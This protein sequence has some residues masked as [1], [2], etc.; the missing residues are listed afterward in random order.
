MEF[1]KDT[2]KQ[3]MFNT[4]SFNLTRYEYIAENESLAMEALGV[5][6]P[7]WLTDAAIQNQGPT[8]LIDFLSSLY[9]I[10][11][12]CFNMQLETASRARFAGTTSIKCPGGIPSQSDPIPS[13]TRPVLGRL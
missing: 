12:S 10:P 8:L 5:D 13:S 2:F 6:P 7:V 11:K 1:M 9:G 3:T 4:I